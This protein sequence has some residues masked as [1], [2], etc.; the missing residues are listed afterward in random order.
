MKNREIF[1]IL[2]LLILSSPVL[3]AQ[4][5]KNIDHQNL[6]WTRYCTQLT[7]NDKWSVHSEF[8][9]RIFVKPVKENLFVARVQLRNKLTD[10]I[11]LGAGFAYFS[12]ATQDSE[13]VLGFNVPEY[14]GQQDISVKQ[15][16]GKIILIHRYQIEERFFHDFN[17]EGLVDGTT[18]F[19]RFRYRLQGDY[20]FWKNEEQYLKAIISDEI[21]INGGNKIIK[22][23]FDQNRIYAALQFGISPSLAAEVGYLNSF[24]QRA[25]GVDYFDRNIIRISIYHKLKI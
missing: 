8:D 23:T 1:K 9:N 5:E 19:L 21:M 3:I 13:V 20:A 15:S 18:F 22:N 11:E 6:L 4:T 10:K 12:V 14:R 7:L 25:S 24:Q 16:L 17:K 2:F